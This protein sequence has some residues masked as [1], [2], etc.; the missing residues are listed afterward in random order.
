MAK[1][2][3]PSPFDLPATWA[4]LEGGVSIMMTRLT[5]GMS[6]QRYMELYTVA[7]NHCTSSRMNAPSDS[8]GS[9]GRAAGANLM[10][11]ELYDRLSKYFVSHLRTVAA[12]ADD[13]TDEALL[14]YYVAEW[15]RYTTGANFVHRLF[16]YLNRHWVRREKEEGKK[17]T[18]VVYTLALVQWKTHM[19]AAVQK[20]GR[21]VAALL[22][23]IEKQRNGETIETSLVKKVVDSLVSLGLDE[24]DS[25]RQNLDVY[26]NEFERPFLVA[27]EIYYKAESETFIAENSVT[28]YMRKAEA[29]LREEESRVEM[30]LHATTKR[31]LVQTCDAVLVRGHAQMM[32][33]EFQSLLDLAKTDDLWRMY[34]LLFRIS[35]GLEPLRE[36][37]ELHVKRVGLAAVE[38]VAGESADAVDA[39]AY[40]SALLSVH[41]SSLEMVQAAF[42]SEAGF[43]AALDKACRDFM[44]RNKATGTSNSKSPELL[45][46]HSDGLLKKSNKSTEEQ[47]LEDA[48][49]QVMVVFKYIEDKDVFQKFYSKMLAKRLVNFSS[50]SDDAE[51][52]MIAKLKEACGFE[53]TNKLQRM[54]TDMGL[55]KELNDSFREVSGKNA[56]D[57]GSSKGGDVDFYALVLANGFWPLAEPTTEFVIPTELLATYTRFERYYGAKHSGRRLAWLWQLSKNDLKTNYLS[58]KLILQTS[59]YQSAVLLQY[60]ASDSLTMAELHKAT[61]LNE[62]ALKAALGP[63]VKSKLL[64]QDGDSYDINEDFKSKK[65]RVNLNVPVK[66]E[67]KAESSD[68]MRTVDEDRRMLL[69]ATIVRIMKAR[70]T[71]KH[72][73]LVQEV[74]QQVSAR[75][76]PKVPDIKKAIDQL[77]D[78]EYLERVEGERDKY[79]YLA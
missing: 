35:D 43:L 4:Y 68:V 25:T 67:Q 58:Q 27:T 76:Q 79:Q 72:T 32:W 5:E 57:A 65:V 52:S 39:A 73:N 53:Y 75:F 41:A 21:L 56:D 34:N 77:I 30:Y 23:Q 51:A 3:L 18:H 17:D 11:A 29:R 13:L 19:F 9:S 48:L 24:S 46:K 12:G 38:K 69:Q 22:K 62:A 31:Q 14:R 47:G 64:V 59:A 61:G 40:V 36:K 66:S 10:G 45:A 16:A 7:Y 20:K 60:N 28:D 71:L 1:V 74:V 37:F 44:N 70:K 8:L 55:S 78:K 6:Y 63:L 50:A 26:R 15:D 33:D 42:R 54:F 49:N 2:Q